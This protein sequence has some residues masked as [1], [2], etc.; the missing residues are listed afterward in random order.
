MPCSMQAT[1]EWK[2]NPSLNASQCNSTPNKMVR[3]NA[4]AKKARYTK[5]KKYKGHHC[6]CHHEITN[7]RSSNSML[8]ASPSMIPWI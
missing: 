7:S 5:E 3:G 2:E 4:K 8:S 6:R 1:Q